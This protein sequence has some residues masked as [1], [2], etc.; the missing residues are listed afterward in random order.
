MCSVTYHGVI[1]GYKMPGLKKFSVKLIRRQFYYY[2]YYY[3]YCN[4]LLN[5]Q[6]VLVTVIRSQ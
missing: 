4:G 3:Y 2:Y 5:P 6:F 1:L